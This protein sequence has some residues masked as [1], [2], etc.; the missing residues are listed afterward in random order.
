MEFYH[1]YLDTN[2]LLIIDARHYS[3]AQF[4]RIRG[5]GVEYSEY[6]GEAEIMFMQ[7]ENIHS[8]RSSFDCISMFAMNGEKFAH[9]FNCQI[10]INTWPATVGWQAS[11]IPIGWSTWV[12]YWSRP[13]ILLKHWMKMAGQWSFIVQM[14]GIELPSWH[15][16]PKYCSMDIIEL[17]RW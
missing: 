7:L 16:C 10:W 1:W 13:L 12:N 15:H 3:T 14:V 5:G 4:N 17:Y 8:V 11:R 9:C 6:Y 2:R